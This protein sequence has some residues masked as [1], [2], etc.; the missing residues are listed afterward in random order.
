MVKTCLI[1]VLNKFNASN[2]GPKFRYVVK[3]SRSAF[4]VRYGGDHP[5]Y[6]LSF[7][8]GSH[9]KDWYIDVF[10]LSLT[11]SEDQ[12]QFLMDTR[13]GDLA[14][15]RKE[16]V[17][18]NLISILT[19]EMLHVVGVRHC[20]AQL[21]EMETCVRF[22]PNLSDDENNEEL[23]MQPSLDWRN[24]YRLKWLSRT[25]QE[26]QQIYAMRAGERIGCHSIRDVSWKVGAKQRKEI[27]LRNARCC[28]A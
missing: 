8:P 13:R 12:E 25:V 28:V 10:K 24:L 16:A 20:D 1:A 3:P 22:P 6:A 14:K 23:L 9:P 4:F 21:T 18:R 15:A 11:L 26:I 5:L 19:H 2:V 17:K 7:F 27:A